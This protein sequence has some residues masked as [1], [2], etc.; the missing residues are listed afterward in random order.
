M[1]RPSGDPVTAFGV[2]MTEHE[3]ASLL[4]EL[5]RRKADPLP[6]MGVSARRVY[7]DDIHRVTNALREA[8]GRKTLTYQ[9]ID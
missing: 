5:G 2:I 4:Y 1:D 6:F 9:F 8:I 7:N 3:I